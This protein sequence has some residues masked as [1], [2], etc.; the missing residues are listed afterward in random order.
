MTNLQK[1]IYRQ[2]Y[3]KSLYDFVKDFWDTADPSKFIDGPLVQ[4][5]CEIFQYKCKKWTG[6]KDIKIDLPKFDKDVDVIDVRSD[7]NKLNINVPPRH[8]KSK[9]FNVFGPVWLWLN[10]PIKAVSV[11]H[12]GDLATKMN[13]QRKAIIDSEKF[14]NIFGDYIQLTSNSKSYLKD[15]RKGELYSVNRDSFT[16]YG[17]DIIINDDLTNAETA[18]KDKEEMNNAWAYYENT[19]PSRVNDIDKCLVINIQQRLAPN[20]ITG[21]LMND[22]KK[23]KLYDFLILPAQFERDTVWIFPISG[24]VIKF[25][26]GEYLWP[27]R[28]GNYETLKA[29]V[30]E[31]VFETQY[32]Q[33]PKATDAAVIRDEDIN[34]ISLTAAPSIEQ[35]DMIYGSHDFP[36]KD[37]EKS[38]FLG[39]I[40]AYRKGSNVYIYDCLEKHMAFKKSVQYV[41]SLHELY[42]GIIQVIEDKANGSPI[43][44]QTQEEIPGIK[45][46]QP[47]T[48]SK[49]QRLESASMYM[50]NVY[51]VATEWDDLT[52]SYH[53][54]DAL[55]NL[56]NRLLSF[57]YVEHDDVVD[58]FSMLLLFIFMD[59][60][61]AVYGRSFNNNN[62]IKEGSIQCDLTTV[63]FNKE[64]DNWKST[65]IGVKYGMETK[66][67]ILDEYQ[68]KASI[69]EGL[70]LLKERYKKKM[71]V[72]CSDGDSL[73]GIHNKGLY[74]EK[75]TIEDFDRSVSQL[76]LAFTNKRVLLSNNCKECQSEIET[77]K[78]N[79]STDDNDLKYVTEKDGFIACMRVA[80]HYY[81]GI[82]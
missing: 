9:I 50:N 10:Y 42:P 28:F 82:I 40:L 38:D 70:E 47:G 49:T 30:G 25:K 62:I 60:R 68:F 1:S 44:E 31:S 11:S 57:P 5:Y 66:L 37:K 35:A 63:F 15:N 78:Y 33:K 53:L 34:I 48:Q 81:G 72:D 71:F 21:R 19:M 65:K 55:D 6:F 64:G 32:L 45:A 77:F 2:L 39:S 69:E 26:K 41:T 51:F 79:K 24:R 14:Q 36:V 17:G 27:E 20:D 58:A 16:G 54:S 61:Y 3:K 4:F 80:L 22:K 59:K 75:Y 43:I 74:I 67:I 7:K 56:K 13:E 12:T 76:N 52:Q 23:A 73:R 46:F 29:E 18:R 8:T